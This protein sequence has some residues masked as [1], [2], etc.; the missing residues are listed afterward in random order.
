MSW[1][2]PAGK[3]AAISEATEVT[4]RDRADFTTLKSSSSWARP[5]TSKTETGN[6]AVTRMNKYLPLV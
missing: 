6:N 4:A 5:L 1:R 3:G 2:L